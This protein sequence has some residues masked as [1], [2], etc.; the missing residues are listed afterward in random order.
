VVEE[1]NSTTAAVRNDGYT[2][3]IDAL[4][5][6]NMLNGGQAGVL[7][8]GGGEGESKVYP[9]T[10]NDGRLS[11]MDALFVINDLNGRVSA[12]GEGEGGSLATPEVCS[13]G[14]AL[15]AEGESD[16]N[17]FKS[18]GASELIYGPMAQASYARFADSLY[19]I[20]DDEED[21]LDSVLDELVSDIDRSWNN[22]LL[23]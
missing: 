21:E 14:V 19:D 18:A 9:D 8:S 23:G 7:G 15:A 3:P 10:N 16:S 2:S 22:P 13:S 5:I 4:I 6:I 11:A 17:E 12:G 20:S 1:A